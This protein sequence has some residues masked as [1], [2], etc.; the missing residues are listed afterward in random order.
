MTERDSNG[1]IDKVDR[2]VATMK[3]AMR[4]EFGVV[5]DA[6]APIDVPRNTKGQF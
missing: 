6:K 1:E 2:S 3:H 4:K 5:A